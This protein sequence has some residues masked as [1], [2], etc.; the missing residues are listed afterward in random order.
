VAFRQAVHVDPSEE[1][2]CQ[3]TKILLVRHGHV[4]GINPERFRGRADLPLTATGKAQ[5]QAV[6]QRIAS[7][8][9]PKKVYASPLSRCVETANAIANACRVDSERLEGLID[10]DYGE[11]QGRS[12]EEMSKADPTLFG[13][14]FVTPHLIRFPGG[15]SLQDLV[16][17]SAEA[18]RMILNRHP[19]ETVVLVSH[20]STNRAILLQMV[21]QPLSAYWKLAQDPC[22]LNEID[23]AKGQ[24]RVLRV[25]EACHLEG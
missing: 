15:E 14:W 24:V 10:I 13:S 17:R 18:V 3:L 1:G 2:S 11:W 25:N 23:V 8:W 22:C 19:D 5:T 6:A 7:R 16:A 21:D 12:Y 4:E 9:S 20:D